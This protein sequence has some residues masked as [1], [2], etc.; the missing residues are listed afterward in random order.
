MKPDKDLLLP[1]LHWADWKETA[2]TL[3]LFT[4]IIGKIRLELMPMQAEWGQ[5][6]F[7]V[8][9]RGLASI[10]MPVQYGC[11]DIEFDLISHSIKFYLNNGKKASFSLEE[12]SV[13]DFYL[14]V[15]DVLNYFGVT[16]KINPMTVEMPDPLRLD[17][18]E[19]HNT[20]DREAVQRFHC[21][22]VFIN[23]VFNEFRSRF[24][25]K[26]TPVNFFWGSF[27][28]AVT[29][30][31]GKICDPQPGQD[32]IYRVAMDAE[33]STAG[34]WPGDD[35]FPEASFFAYTYPKPKG[36]EKAKLSPDPA[37][38]SKKKGEFILP[39]EAVRNSADPAKAL[40]GFCET[41][42][43]AGASLAGWDVE[44]LEHKPPVD[45]PHK[46]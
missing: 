44:T 39:Y 8:T 33:Q 32:L 26:Q 34:F 45:P 1:E 35:S 36:I 19:D 5:V 12:N 17:L 46:K 16:V 23:N 42:Y 38:W 20:Y 7:H 18:D 11:L 6:P 10:G 14:K 27:D 9:S 22:L 31:S 30:F 41:T 4:Q 2:A 15:M 21:I 24:S 37:K 25:G 40:L 43:R 3:H 13:A 29:R 28:L